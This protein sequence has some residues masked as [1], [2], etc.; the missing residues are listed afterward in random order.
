M[1]P[2]WQRLLAEAPEQSEVVGVYVFSRGYLGRRPTRYELTAARRAA[3]LYADL[4]E[5]QVLHV[6]T[7][8]GSYGNRATV[9]VAQL[10]ADL[11]EEERLRDVDMAELRH[12]PAGDVHATSTRSSYGTWSN[13]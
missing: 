5:A 1:A 11:S 7:G 2:G 12:R 8:G 10:D 9:L 13:G 3:R 4:G 6:A